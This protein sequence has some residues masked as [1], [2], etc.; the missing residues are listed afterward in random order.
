MP[1]TGHSARYKGS[2]SNRV[3]KSPFQQLAEW[4]AQLLG[5][6]GSVPTITGGGG[7]LAFKKLDASDIDGVMHN[8]ATE[9]LDMNGFDIFTS[10]SSLGL[11]WKDDG[12]NHTIRIGGSN[13]TAG[14]RSVLIMTDGGGDNVV[15]GTSTLTGCHL[16]GQA[17]TLAGTN[18]SIGSGSATTN[19]T[20]GTGDCSNVTIGNVNHATSTKIYGDEVIIDGPSTNPPS[21]SIII[22]T[23]ASAVKIGWSAGTGASPVQPAVSK[24]GFFGVAPITRPTIKR[25][26]E[27]PGAGWSTPEVVVIIK[28]INYLIHILD[29]H[30]GTVGGFHPGLGLLYNGNTVETNIADPL[31]PTNP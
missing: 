3:K 12:I 27:A 2:I 14:T 22:G 28:S 21:G 20:I 11:I 8:P 31:G 18:V 26:N 10:T 7:G 1:G 25:F 15:V 17:I 19:V 4:N 9:D 16:H 29:E 5:A 6:D 13:S 23:D 30:H 24:I